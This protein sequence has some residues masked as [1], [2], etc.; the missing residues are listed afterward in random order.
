MN[1]KILINGIN[2]SS[3]GGKTVLLNFI[4]EISNYTNTFRII[5]LV[6]KTVENEV[7]KCI[8]NTSVELI[9]IKKPNELESLYWYLFKIPQIL[10][11]KNI[12]LVLNFGDIP[13]RT[14]SA[15]QIIYFDWPHAIYP[16]STVW[17]R[18]S[19]V[20]WATKKIKLFIFKSLFKYIDH[21]IAQTN[22]AVNRLKQFYPKNSYTVLNNPV[23]HFSN[24]EED[25]KISF[26]KS[27]FY[28][29]FLTRYYEHK[30]LESIIPLAKE[31]KKNGDNIKIL[32]TIEKNQGSGA[33][34]L[35]NKI[36]SNKLNEIIINVGQVSLAQVTSLY[37][38]IDALFMPTLLESF[39]GTYVESMYFEKPILTSDLDFAK[40]IC[41]NG[42][43]YFNPFN[44]NE[45]LDA[46]KFISENNKEISKLIK[47]QKL[48]LQ[49]FINWE[50][51]TNK[52]IELI[53]KI[54]NE[55]K[56]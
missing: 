46:I 14:K 38:K 20:T 31:I 36:V 19:R 30:N 39:S 49:S 8:T 11:F 28:L 23:S 55:K 42:A 24:E 56:S 2:N 34:K 51:K 10:K 37:K 9:A 26:L 5:I 43:I 33:R 48:Q 45:Q 25:V 15:L 13:I 32:I 1:N 54:L 21:I 6:S 7:Q 40:E 52:I 41:G 35:L 4:K 50:L 22:T 27:N 3:A 47:N 17:K 18:F 29:F 44:T 16:E 53:N 12:Q